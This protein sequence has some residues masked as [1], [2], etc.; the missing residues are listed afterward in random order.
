MR[1]KRNLTLTRR[2]ATGIFA[3]AFVILLLSCS[4]DSTRSEISKETA[5]E[6]S[7]ATLSETVY[8]ISNVNIRSGPG[9]NYSV[10]RNGKK[11]E[12]LPYTLLKDGWYK[13]KVAEGKPEEWISKGVVITYVDKLLREDSQLA[14]LK[15][16]WRIKSGYA[17]AEGVVKNVSGKDL[18]NVKAVIVYRSKR[19]VV[20][21]SSS[22]KVKLNPIPPEQTSTF[23]VK[24]KYAKSMDSADIDF[25]YYS[26]QPIEWYEADG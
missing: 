26:D 18:R 8:P 2:T 14:L 12:E 7:E 17:Y 13:L 11:G 9:T 5:T 16:S 4:D 3:A 25:S 1:K 21:A 20:V 23:T 6:E 24:T 19:G 22:G 15:W 10:I